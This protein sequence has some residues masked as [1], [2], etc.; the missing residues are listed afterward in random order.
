MWSSSSRKTLSPYNFKILSSMLC[1]RMCEP[2]IAVN[3]HLSTLLIVRMTLPETPLCPSY[4][5]RARIQPLWYCAIFQY[6]WIPHEL[7]SL[8]TMPSQTR[9]FLS[10]ARA[11]S[12]ST[13]RCSMLRCAGV[14][15]VFWMPRYSKMECAVI[16]ETGAALRARYCR[17]WPSC[18]AYEKI[19]K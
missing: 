16:T 19:G 6:T 4:L 2:K 11:L 5:D 1:H 14:A 12:V 15:F 7:S 3:V 8:S 18:V 10:P 9:G 13:L 17:C